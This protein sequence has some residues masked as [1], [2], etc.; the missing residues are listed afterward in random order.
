MQPCSRRGSSKSLRINFAVG[1]NNVIDDKKG[2]RDRSGKAP[3]A[4]ATFAGA[5]LPCLNSHI[6]IENHQ[7]PTEDPSDSEASSENLRFTTGRKRS[8][9]ILS[10]SV[11]KLT[12]DHG[13][14]YLG[15]LTLTFS[16]HVLCPK[17]AQKRL[18]SLFSNVIKKRYGDYVGVF[19]RQKSGRIHYH[20]LVTLEQD[21]REGVNFEAFKNRD[22]RSASKYLRDEWAFWRST[23]RKYRFGRTELMP[24]KSSAEAM[25]YYVGKYISKSICADTQEQD[26]GVRLVRYS[27]GARAGNTR[28]AF[29]SDGSRRW[30]EATGFFAEIVSDIFERPIENMDDLSELLG[31]RWAYKNRAFIL[32]LSDIIASCE[33]F[34]DPD[35][36]SELKG[37]FNSTLIKR[38]ITM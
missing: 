5:A 14:G 22:Y 6:S 7:K 29:S 8:A 32:G 10:E 36:R 19:E 1:L 31:P 24:I 20:L 13:L 28:F 4:D 16:D 17:Q 25:K 2:P 26:K 34:N 23:A 11:E 38:I 30:R 15:F 3:A 27:K 33:G 12:K 37:S 21:I 35:T 18:N 9:F